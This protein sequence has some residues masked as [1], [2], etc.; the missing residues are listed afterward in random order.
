MIQDLKWAHLENPAGEPIWV[1]VNTLNMVCVWCVRCTNVC[2][3][4]Q[5]SDVRIYS[6]WESWGRMCVCLHVCVWAWNVI[7]SVLHVFFV[8]ALLWTIPPLYYSLTDYWWLVKALCMF[9]SVVQI[10]NHEVHLLWDEKVAYATNFPHLYIP[11]HI[12]LYTSAGMF[13]LPCQKS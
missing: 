6:G 3:R 1:Y 12:Y 2:L 8:W 13:S 5:T 4:V 7:T 11:S 10:K 9:V